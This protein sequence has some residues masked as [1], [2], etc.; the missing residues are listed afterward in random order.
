MLGE[1]VVIEMPDGRK[2]AGTLTTAERDVRE[3]PPTPSGWRV[4]EPGD[5]TIT[6]TEARFLE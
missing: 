5:V 1:R 2:I 3:G 6:I 4:V